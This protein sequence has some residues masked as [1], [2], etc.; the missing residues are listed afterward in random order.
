MI[1]TFDIW[2]GKASKNI[3]INCTRRQLTMINNIIS[4]IEE[5]LLENQKN[6]MNINEVE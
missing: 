5:A 3:S 4:D 6:N 2:T 1:G